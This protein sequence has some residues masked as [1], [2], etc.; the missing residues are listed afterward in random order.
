MSINAILDM[1]KREQYGLTFSIQLTTSGR[2]LNICKRNIVGPY[3]YLQ[4][5][6]QL[7]PFETQ[8]FINEINHAL[9]EEYYEPYFISD[10]VEADDVELTYPN[11]IINGN[12]I[13]MQ[14][15]LAL[16]QEWQT[17]ITA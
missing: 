11:V 5:L 9:N 10:G 15:M 17:F 16:L 7:S 1:T 3:S 13:A 2:L 4:I 8:F 6:T 12:I 14:D